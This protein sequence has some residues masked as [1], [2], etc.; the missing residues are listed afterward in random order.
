ML[1]NV[2]P[3]S[4]SQN[5]P[6]DNRAPVSSA[7]PLRLRHPQLRT[8]EDGVDKEVPSHAADNPKSC[9]PLPAASVDK[10]GIQILDLQKNPPRVMRLI[11][12]TEEKG[13]GTLAMWISPDEC[14]LLV[15]FAD[16]AVRRWD[17]WQNLLAPTLLMEEGKGGGVWQSASFSS[18]GQ[19]LAVSRDKTDGAKVKVWNLKEALPTCTI[20]PGKMFHVSF[21]PNGKSLAGFVDKSAVRI[22]DLQ[23]RLPTYV[24]LNGGVADANHNLSSL[25]YGDRFLALNIKDHK[26]PRSNDKW[27]KIWDLQQDTPKLVRDVRVPPGEPMSFSLDGIFFA[28]TLKNWDVRKGLDAIQILNLEKGTAF[29]PFA[30]EGQLMTISFS[31]DGRFLASGTQDGHIRLVDLRTI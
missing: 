31:P 29:R 8:V 5:Q 13:K 14:T 17:L 7:M 2:Q 26:N 6:A 11:E 25:A 16:G 9:P 27:L 30:V 18:C 15:A 20:L 10:R 22:W 4:S 28:Y 23:A 21:S 24:E 3:Q 1:D 12:D 19:F